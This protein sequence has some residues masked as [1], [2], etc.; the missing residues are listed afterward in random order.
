MEESKPN[1]LLNEIFD[2]EARGGLYMVKQV[3]K[4][5][6]GIQNYTVEKGI[7]MIDESTDY[8]LNT[9][10]VNLED[11]V[12]TRTITYQKVK[13]YDEKMINEIKQR[14]QAMRNARMMTTPENDPLIENSKYS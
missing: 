6:N 3:D 1:Q 9:E 13:G 12:R 10:E 4:E 11:Y 2:N 14:D 8:R 5:A 7:S